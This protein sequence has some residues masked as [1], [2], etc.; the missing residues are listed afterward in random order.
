MNR[1][2]WVSLAV[3]VAW[4]L[5]LAAGP[6]VRAENPPPGT[7]EPPVEAPAVAPDAEKPWSVGLDLTYNSKYVWRGIEVTE[8]PVLQPSVTFAC[9][10][11]SLNIWG[12]MDT[13]DVNDFDNQFLEIDYTIDYS[14]SWK[15]LEFSVGAI[16]YAFPQAHVFDTTEVYGAIGLDV[17][18]SPTLTVYTDVDETDGVYM[19]LSFGHSFEDCWQPCEGVS[20]GIDLAAGFAWGSRKHNQ[21]YYGTGSGWADATVSLGLPF[22]IGDHVT[23]TPSANVSWIL[24]DDISSALGEDSLFWAGITFAVS[25]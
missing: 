16:H 7:G 8:D 22:A 20:M 23:V 11:L 14:T 10:D 1:M 24:D 25:F 13:T 18:T 17:L 4:G 6:V 21:F 12:N 19:L 3:G 5:V 2:T 15:C 9:G